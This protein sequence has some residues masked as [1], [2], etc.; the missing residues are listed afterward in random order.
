MGAKAEGKHR[1]VIVRCAVRQ[2][3][4]GAWSTLHGGFA[5]LVGFDK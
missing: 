3:N 1:E 2:K 5:R 4:Y